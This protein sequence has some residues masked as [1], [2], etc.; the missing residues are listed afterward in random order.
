MQIARL[1]PIRTDSYWGER[2]DT[3]GFVE[4]KS[5][6]Q[7]PL[8]LKISC[9]FVYRPWASRNKSLTQY[10]VCPAIEINE[11]GQTI[12]SSL[13]PDLASAYNRKRK[14]LPFGL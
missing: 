2:T 5:I 8:T 11:K 4:A 6:K 14:D 10:K 7:D 3:I 12:K 13:N 9:K 1:V